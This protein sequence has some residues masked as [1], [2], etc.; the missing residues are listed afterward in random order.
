MLSNL[1]FGSPTVQPRIPSIR[2]SVPDSHLS[3]TSTVFASIDEELHDAR[4]VHSHGQ[5]ED[6]R[7]A[8]DRVIKKVEELVRRQVCFS[9]AVM[10]RS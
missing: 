7:Y 2:S 4:R 6:L 9:A 5:E 3:P 1:A 8:L 10:N